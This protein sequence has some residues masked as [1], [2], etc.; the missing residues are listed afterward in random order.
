[1]ELLNRSAIITGGNRGFGKAVAQAFVQ[2]GANVLLCAR[3]RIVLE[4][5]RQEIAALASPNQKVLAQVCDVA[6]PEEVR[7]LI[8]TAV[9]AFK[10]VHILVN[11]A[12]VYGPKGPIDTVDW[13]AWVQAVSINLHGVVLP[14][15]ILLPH[16]RKQG[17]G[18]IINLSGGGATSPMPNLSAY[19]ASKA[20]VVRF[21][22]TVA[23]EVREAR[24]DVNAVA[25]GALDTRLLDEVIEAGPEKVGQSFHE[26]MLK[27]KAQGGTPLATGAAL[28][29]F[30]ASAKSDGITGK[31]IS[32]VWDPWAQL[33]EH[34]DELDN[35]DIYTLRRIVPAER[36][37]AWGNV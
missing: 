10:V 26:R 30:L 1:M 5:A 15:A 35:T 11:N 34:Q 29:V 31:L 25:P 7:R 32:A 19:A 37:M 9:E 17:Y 2:A 23:L 22:E 33:P 12:G 8:D 24:I 16:L 20:A 14:T 4:E 13:D 6:N 36:G 28:C 18:K 27:I 21:T 3:D